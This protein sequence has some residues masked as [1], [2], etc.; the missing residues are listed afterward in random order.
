VAYIEVAPAPELRSLVACYWRLDGPAE[1][2]RVLPDGCI[3]IL[4]SGEGSGARVVGTMSRAIVAPSTSRGAIGIRFLPGEAARLLPSAPRELTDGGAELRELWADAAELE[5]AL[6]AALERA[7]FAGIDVILR[8]HR[9]RW[10]EPADLRIRTAVDRLVEGRSVREAALAA[11]LSERQLARRFEARV[12]IAP[13][14]FGRVMRLQRAA[15]AL[16]SGAT[17]SAAAAIAGYS[18]QAHFTRDTRALADTTPREM[19]DSFKPAAGVAA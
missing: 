7:A 16:A 11:A 15:V 10:C 17:A 18:D 2:H 4:V 14:L 5:D 13:K 6:G 19:S 8:R 3:D 1:P 9:E 12:G